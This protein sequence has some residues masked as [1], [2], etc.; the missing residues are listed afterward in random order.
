[1]GIPLLGTYSGINRKPAPMRHVE[2]FL[3]PPFTA[4]N[5]CLLGGLSAPCDCTTGACN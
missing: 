3:L 5:Q 2:Q 1:M 4:S